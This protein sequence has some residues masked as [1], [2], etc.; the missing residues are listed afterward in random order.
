MTEFDRCRSVWNP[1]ETMICKSL[2]A[3]RA[4]GRNGSEVHRRT[5]SGCSKAVGDIA[6]YLV[7]VTGLDQRNDATAEAAASHAC[8]E[9]SGGCSRFDGEIYLR[10]GDLEVVTHRF[11]RG[12]QQRCQLG[13]PAGTQDF[14]SLQHPG[15][16][17]NDM[18]YPAFVHWIWKLVQRG[19][20]VG[21][22][23]QGRH[24]E[25]PCRFL[26]AGSARSVFAVY[27][28]VRGLGVQHQDLQ[29][30]ASHIEKDLFGYIGP[31]IEKQRVA[32]GAQRRCCLIHE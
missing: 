6:S 11:V 28:R 29:T 31:A 26:A 23:A 16:L 3:L 27:Q 13:D 1:I 2:E 25:Q 21:D 7:G 24:A 19:L 17:G 15:V 30:S 9:G 22:V 32:D 18:S 12:I 14:D 20:E 4:G 8:A 5:V 10:H